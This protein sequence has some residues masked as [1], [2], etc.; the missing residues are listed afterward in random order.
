MAYGTY[1]HGCT[2]TKTTDIVLTT[3]VSPLFCVSTFESEASVKNR[4]KSRYKKYGYIHSYLGLDMPDIWY[5]I[6]EL[7]PSYD[8][9]GFFRVSIECLKMITERDPTDCVSCR[10]PEYFPKDQ[11]NGKGGC[12]LSSNVNKG[13]VAPIRVRDPSAS[14]ALFVVAQLRNRSRNLDCH[15]VGGAFFCV[16]DL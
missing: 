15:G 1:H 11:A 13:D 5:K 6:T 12:H 14:S 9:C 2:A 7:G 3:I 16:F 4:C 8:E 10:R